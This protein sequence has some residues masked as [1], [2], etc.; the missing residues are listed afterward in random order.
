MPHLSPADVPRACDD[1]VCAAVELSDRARSSTPFRSE[2]APRQST[3]VP[4]GQG[5]NSFNMRDYMYGPDEVEHQPSDVDRDCTKEL[6]L[7]LADVKKSVVS[8]TDPFEW[9][10]AHKSVYPNLSKLARK[11]LGAV[12]TSVPSERAF[13]TSGNVVTVKRSSLTPA[14]VRDLVFVGEN[15]RRRFEEDK[16]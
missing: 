10:R 9:W 6:E 5:C 4:L 13:A 1:I 12:A 16:V 7:Y 14:M 8:K 2:I 11:W 3:P 15:W